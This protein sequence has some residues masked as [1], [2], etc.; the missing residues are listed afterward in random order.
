MIAEQSKELKQLSYEFSQRLAWGLNYPGTLPPPQ[1]PVS[2]GKLGRAGSGPMSP[3]GLCATPGEAGDAN[4]DNNNSCMSP[5]VHS[6]KILSHPLS[7][8]ILR[9]IPMRE[10]GQVH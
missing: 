9:G 2:S 3:L 10:V 8:L 5:V 7:H 4:T 6:R 1:C